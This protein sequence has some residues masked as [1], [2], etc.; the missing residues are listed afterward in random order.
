MGY[1]HGKI[2][3]WIF[4]DLLCSFDPGTSCLLQAYNL[5][6]LKIEQIYIHVKNNANR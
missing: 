2:E 4:G 5:L 3:F 6:F 1:N